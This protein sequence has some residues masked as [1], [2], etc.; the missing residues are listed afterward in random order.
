MA[1]SL[2]TQKRDDTEKRDDGWGW[3]RLAAASTAVLGAVLYAVLREE[4]RVFYND[5]KIT[6]DDVGLSQVEI[7]AGSAFGVLTLALIVAAIVGVYVI[8]ARFTAA[9]T[10]R[11]RLPQPTRR[12]LPI[13][14][15]LALVALHVAIRSRAHQA[16]DCV[17]AGSTIRYVTVLGTPL[18]NVRA[19]AATIEWLS[20]A[21]ERP[22]LGARLLFLGQNDGTV[23]L[24]DV[25]AHAPVRLPAGDVLVRIRAVHE[26]CM[27]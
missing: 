27:R 5:L 20:D 10:D 8:A 9:R 21:R 23:V 14:L 16:G 13:F 19:Q 22:H 6:P 4:Y 26:G 1:S 24:F 18:L 2:A 17:K 3:L 15:L 11:V 25:A 12:S 7:V